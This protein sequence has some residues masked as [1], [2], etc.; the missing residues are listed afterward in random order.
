V[1]LLIAERQN[2]P[3]SLRLARAFRRRYAVARN[4]RVLRLG[5]G[6]A[7]GSLGI[8]L[9]A[10]VHETTDYVAAVAG[11]WAL[12]SRSVLSQRE[13]LEQDHGALAQEV[14]DTR[15]FQLPWNSTACGHSPA[16]EDIRCW[17]ERQTEEGL[18]DWYAD[19]SDA[20]RPL[21]VLICQRSSVTWARQDHAAYAALLR[22]LVGA[23]LSATVVGALAFNLT[24]GEYLLHLGLPALPATLD[25]LDIANINT[26]LS[27]RRGRLEHEVDAL[28]TRAVTSGQAPAETEARRLQDEIYASRRLAGVPGWFYK[29]TRE[30]RE[31]NMREAAGEQLEL[32][33]DRLRL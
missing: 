10:L 15:V 1:S 8:L 7:I 13:R 25:V 18:R 27:R 2:E 33:P 30:R 21:D 32:L 3:Q 26:E 22:V 20:L 23:A 19:V 24:L 9:A 5:V 14:F 4:W 29:L 31:R 6:V 16:P 12:I 11:A 17:G 28:L